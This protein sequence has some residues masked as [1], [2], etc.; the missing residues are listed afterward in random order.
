M[1]CPCGPAADL[2]GLTE[3]EPRSEL[4]LIECAESLLRRTVAVEV[5]T[6]VCVL[7]RCSAD[8]GAFSVMGPTLVVAVT[9]LGATEKVAICPRQWT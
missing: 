8:P 9:D 4:A 6:S 5:P 3:I 7:S 2:D 1:S